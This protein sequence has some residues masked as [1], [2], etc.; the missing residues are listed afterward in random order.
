MAYKT[1]LVYVDEAERCAPVLKAAKLLATRNK[2]HV[3][4]LHVIP[5]IQV[6]SAAEAQLPVEVFE[7]QRRHN[8]EVAAKAEAEFMDTF[9]GSSLSFEWRAVEEKGITIGDRVMEHALVADA[10]VAGQI[11]PDVASR[12]RVGTPEK[13]LLSGRRPMLLVPYIGF[14]TMGTR[15]GIA[16]NGS[17]EASRAVFDA[18]PVLKKAKSVALITVDMEGGADAPASAEAMAQSLERHGITAGVHHSV[19]AGVD[20]GSVLLSRLA[21]D[22]IDLLVMGGYGHSRLREF[23]F[24]GATRS[25]LQQMTVPVLM[26]H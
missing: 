4:G 19:S 24:G 26:S 15:V 1:I 18:L 13:L 8:T 23:V 5:D 14:E 6:Y 3:I 22:G 21:D 11:D 16:W 25:I 12:R 10:V 17:A 9:S 7:I 2:A 20:I